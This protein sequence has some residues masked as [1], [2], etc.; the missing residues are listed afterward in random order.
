MGAVSVHPTWSGTVLIAENV[1]KEVA[2]DRI[3]AMVVYSDDAIVRNNVVLDVQSGS[4]IALYGHRAA[5]AGNVLR[6][7]GKSNPGAIWSD[8]DSGW[9]W[10]NRVTDWSPE[11]V[12]PEGNVHQ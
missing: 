5:V 11:L 7:G 1:V 9:F 12:L 2:G 10:G 8:K 6:G 3:S 4:G